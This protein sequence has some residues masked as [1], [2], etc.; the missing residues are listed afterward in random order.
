MSH[1]YHNDHHHDFSHGGSFRERHDDHRYGFD[2]Q[3][4]LGDRRFRKF[5]VPAII[6]IA[7]AA[8][9]LIILLFPVFE[10][11]IAYIGENGIQGIVK[12]IWSG[13]KQ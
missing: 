12:S 9:L 11:V 13:S 4:I 5:L 2:F 6:F 10:K 7:G 1:H 8:I 3:R